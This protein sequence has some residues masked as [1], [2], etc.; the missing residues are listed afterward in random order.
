MTYKWVYRPLYPR[1]ID[2]SGLRDRQARHQRRYSV[3]ASGRGMQYVIHEFFRH[4][5]VKKA[6]L[7]QGLGTVRQGPRSAFDLI[8]PQN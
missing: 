1:E 8:A 6:G 3:E 2:P 5:H 7:R 4:E